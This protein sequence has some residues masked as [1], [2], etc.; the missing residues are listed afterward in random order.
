[1]N[2][3]RRLLASISPED[4]KKSIAIIIVWGYGWQIVVWGPLSWIILLISHFTDRNLPIPPIL[5]W[6]QLAAATATLA[7]V[8]GI[9]TWREKARHQNVV[10]GT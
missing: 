6:E 10:T 7:T 1:M 4:W 5:P 8:G 2:V 3:V 9:E